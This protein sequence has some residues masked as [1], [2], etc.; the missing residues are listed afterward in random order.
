MSY[1]DDPNFDDVCTGL[2]EGEVIAEIR[3]VNPEYESKNKGTK[4][5][6]IG[7]F[8][9]SEGEKYDREKWGDP[10][11]LTMNHYLWEPHSGMKDNGQFSKRAMKEFVEALESPS[12]DPQ[13]WVGQKVLLRCKI[14][15]SEEYDDK[16]DIKKVLRV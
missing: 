5:V 15:V 16:T 2:F 12:K 7:L 11:G 1:L 13:D 6:E 4:A 10:S 3:K 9:E 14:S 8:I